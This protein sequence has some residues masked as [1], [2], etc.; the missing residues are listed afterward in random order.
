MS[1]DILVVGSCNVDMVMR[2]PRIPA[3]G[4]T[5]TGGT[6]SRSFGGKGANVAVAAARLGAH[7]ALVSAV[8]DDAAG[9]E[10]RA[11]LRAAGVADD[12]LVEVDAPTGVA[13]VAVDGQAENA[14]AVAPGANALLSGPMVVAALDR[15][16]GP[17]TFVVAD[18]EVP[19]APVRAAAQWCRDHGTVLI[20]DPAPARALD[21][22]LL[23][24]C[25][26]LTPNRGELVGLG[27]TVAE[28]LQ[29]GTAN[30]VVTLGAA[31]TELH[32][33]DR[34]VLRAAAFPV[35]AMDSTGAGDAFVAGLGVAWQRGRSLE[36]AVRHGAATGALATRGLGARAALP[37][38]N[39][40]EDLL[41]L[42][43]ARVA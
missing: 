9:A 23:G 20:L 7:V 34:P 30:V 25:A 12:A 41:A 39:E 40:V 31:G 6:L 42:S 18:L 5:V 43:A 28:L 10:V 27:V 22:D 2:L 24:S 26:L 15:L 19:D 36:D 17:G 16:A 21:R 14:I 37:T 13:H 3:P 8:G 4:E 35:E 38:A 33:A 11:D 1:A 32:R 29:A